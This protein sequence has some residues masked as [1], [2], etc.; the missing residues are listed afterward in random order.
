MDVDGS[1]PHPQVLASILY[2]WMWIRILSLAVDVDGFRL[3]PYPRGNP[4]LDGNER[5]APAA[6]L[7]EYVLMALSSAPYSKDMKVLGSVTISWAVFN[8]YLNK[9]S[10]IT[11]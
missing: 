8:M 3:H 2:M 9:A 4:R 1:H 10:K 7:H 5:R 6:T 11:F